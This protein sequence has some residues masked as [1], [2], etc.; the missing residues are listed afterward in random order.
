MATKNKQAKK[1]FNYSWTGTDKSGKTLK[2][3]MKASSDTLVK[4]ALRGRGITTTK[5]TKQNALFQK[6]VKQKEIAVITR[7]L[8]TMIRAG[9]PVL[10]SFEIVAIGHTNPAVTKL[11]H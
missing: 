7:Q 10:Q 3:E 11:L 8:A 4:V 9:V 5:I 2:G 6:R 1:E